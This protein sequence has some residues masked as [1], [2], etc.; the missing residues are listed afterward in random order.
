MIIFII[1]VFPAPLAPI[2][3]KIS[4]VPIAKDILLSLKSLYSF[5]TL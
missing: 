2:K 5:V 1:V 3:P 4:P